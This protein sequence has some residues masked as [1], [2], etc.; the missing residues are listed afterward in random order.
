MHF[1]SMLC[2]VHVIIIETLTG[3]SEPSSDEEEVLFYGPPTLAEHRAVLFMNRFLQPESPPDLGVVEPNDQP[4]AGP[5]PEPPVDAHGSH[6][7]SSEE[8]PPAAPLQPPAA[9]GS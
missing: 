5:N 8:A 9:E 2:L 6:A 7:M 3:H 1:V 4:P